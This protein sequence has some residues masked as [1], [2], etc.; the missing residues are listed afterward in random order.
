MFISFPE[1]EITNNIRKIN[2][3]KYLI[4]SSDKTNSLYF[5]TKSEYNQ[6]LLLNLTKNYKKAPDKYLNKINLKAQSIN[7]DV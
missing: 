3:S 1:G 6:F 4:I 5:I 2:K 7:N